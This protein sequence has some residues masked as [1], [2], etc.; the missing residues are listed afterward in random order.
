VDLD[1]ENT[2]KGLAHFVTTPAVV[3][4]DKVIV[5]SKNMRQAYVK[6]RVMVAGEH[7]RGYGE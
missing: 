7:T 5:Q 4:A 1:N 3:N 6:A 2:I